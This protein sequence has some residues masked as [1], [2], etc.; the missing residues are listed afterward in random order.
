MRFT[1]SLNKLSVFFPFFP[2]L[3]HL[4]FP[5]KRV[6]CCL[7]QKRVE[8][9]FTSCR[10]AF[11]PN[12]GQPHFSQNKCNPFGCYIKKLQFPENSYIGLTPVRSGEDADN[13]KQLALRISDWYLRG[14]ADTSS[15]NGSHLALTTSCRRSRSCQV[16]Q[17]FPYGV[18]IHRE[19]II[20][21]L[22]VDS[23]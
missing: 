23:P 17:F 18:V 4:Q 22:S 5:I 3:F 1:F 8:N 7:V 12:S 13:D 19:P 16:A 14:S 11:A 2:Y 21:M 15:V 20:S 10:L 9:Y 6:C